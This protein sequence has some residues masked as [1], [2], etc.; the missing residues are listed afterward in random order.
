MR[1]KF[2][3]ARR[4]KGADRPAKLRLIA[5][6]VTWAAGEIVVPAK[7][8]TQGEIVVPAKAGTQG[9]GHA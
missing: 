8:G 4:K 6:T 2:Y 1:A 3:A 5:L 7:A 9:V